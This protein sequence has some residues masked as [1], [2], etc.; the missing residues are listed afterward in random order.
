MEPNGNYEGDFAQIVLDGME[1]AETH[2][3]YDDSEI[4]LETHSQYNIMNV[5]HVFASAAHDEYNESIF[6]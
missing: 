1:I 4:N 3:V 6:S 2:Y 5:R